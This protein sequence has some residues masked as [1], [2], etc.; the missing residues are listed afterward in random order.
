MDCKN[1]EACGYKVDGD[2]CGI[3]GKFSN[4]VFCKHYISQPNIMYGWSMDKNLDDFVTV[5]DNLKK[6]GHTSRAETILY[7][8]ERCRRAEARVKA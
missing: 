1:K 8:I 3:G 5:A 4:G 6:E 7:L 2:K